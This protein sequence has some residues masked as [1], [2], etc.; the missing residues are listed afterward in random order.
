[1]AWIGNSYGQNENPPKLIVGVVVDQ[2]RYDLLTRY[3]H[4]FTDGGFKRL[5][6][7]GFF[8]ENMHYNYVPTYTAPGHTSIFTGTTPSI[9]GI[10]GNNWI[11]DEKKEMYCSQDDEVS[12][13]GG[14]EKSGK[15][16]PKNMRVTTVTDQLRLF[17]NKQSK[18][19]GVAIKDRGAIF[20]AGNMANAAYWYDATTG[21]W[22]TSS[23]YMDSLPSWV[24]KFNAKKEYAKYMRQNWDIL[25]PKNKY[26]NPSMDNVPWEEL[27]FKKET[28]S[29]PYIFDSTRYA[30]E[31]RLTPYGNSLTTD[32]A[33]EVLKNE[34]MGR[35]LH[36]DF[37]TVSYSSPD[38]IGHAFGP[39]SM[40][41]EDN[42][43]RLDRD[44]KR[45]LD[46]L[47]QRYG[48]DNYWIFMTADHGVQDVPGFS[49][50]NKIRGGATSSKKWKEKF[51]NYITL[52]T[53]K[54]GFI[55][56]VM[57]E[58]I[59]LHSDSLLQAG[60]TA[61]DIAAIL[62]SMPVEEMTGI[63]GIY[64]FDEISTAPI[65]RSIRE[66]IINGY[67][68][69]RS[70]DIA[71][72]LLPNWMNHGNK[73]T[74]HGSPYNHDGHVPFLFYGKNVKPQSSAIPYEITDIA[75]T[76]S[77]LLGMLHPNGCVGKPIVELDYLRRG[78]ANP[79]ALRR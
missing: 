4:H 64:S 25:Y 68:P 11:Q 53:G 7:G 52:K 34:Q 49:N 67:V 63:W 14:D 48:R 71:I 60:M 66:K 18:V 1:M 57:N 24:Q 5:M 23:W 46:E 12:S 39:Y 40:E 41:I 13:I 78:Y 16:S 17:T 75:P 56:A 33:L 72:L 20:P 58:Q 37:L 9:H 79:P 69:H 77:Y 65:H 21:N 43:Y 26:A 50:D 2:L 54:T 73:G 22:I 62:R 38:Y 47:D 42:Y 32:M 15:M 19:F 8:A 76:I 28:P 70:G 27:N 55:R 59:T 36:T 6:K 45:L 30:S 3:Q 31:I 61:R 44:I 51:E 74:T 10:A 35:G 29:F